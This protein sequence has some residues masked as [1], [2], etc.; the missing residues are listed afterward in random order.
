M[1]PPSPRGYGQGQHAYGASD[2]ESK[3]DRAGEALPRLTGFPLARRGGGNPDAGASLGE[4]AAA[5]L[6]AAALATTVPVAFAAAAQP[7]AAAQLFAAAAFAAA[8]RRHMH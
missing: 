3:H 4:T 5:T 6:A 1:P 7:V 8:A 2:R